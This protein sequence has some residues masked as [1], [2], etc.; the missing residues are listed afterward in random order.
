MLSRSTRLGA[1]SS[2]SLLSA[3]RYNASFS[4]IASN[5]ATAATTDNDITLYQYKICPFCNKVKAYL[6]YHNISYKTIEVNPIS[7]SQIKSLDTDH[8]KVPIAIV[9]NK[10]IV[11]SNDIIKYIDTL[12][13]TTT[14][15]TKKNKNFITKDT[16]H[17]MSWSE[18]KLAV[19]LYPNITRNFSESWKAFE[20]CGNVKE[21]ST[22]DQ[23]GNRYLGP[24]AM[25]FAN[26]KI[27]KKY[28]I[29]NERSELL[30]VIDEW[31]SAL[32]VG[33]SNGSK[34]NFLNGTYI[35]MSDVMVYGVLNAISGLPAFEYLMVERPVLQKWYNAVNKEIQE[36]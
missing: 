8:K 21:W 32:S 26:G 28:G 31:L 20:Y 29:V 15:S 35:T 11:E 5:D 14:S 2:V 33:N 17:W 10:V 3:Y 36:S 22:M 9:N 25:Y 24:V 6:D 18:K 1:V 13:T 27:K 19:M 7:K 34:G 16:D 23:I 12:S 4:T 30:E